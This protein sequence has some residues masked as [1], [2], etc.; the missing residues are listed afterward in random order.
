MF[1]SSSDS[2]LS[3]WAGR[4]RFSPPPTP[5]LPTLARPCV[6]FRMAVRRKE[7]FHATLQAHKVYPFLCAAAWERSAGMPIQGLTR[8]KGRTGP[9]STYPT[10]SQDAASSL[11][12]GTQARHAPA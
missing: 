7:E 6:Y 8:H 11:L 12:S 4:A 1:C 9:P 3:V 2:E 5:L 10:D